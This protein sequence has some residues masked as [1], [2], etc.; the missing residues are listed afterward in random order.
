V[1]AFNRSHRFN[2]FN[3]IDLK[4]IQAEPYLDRLNCELREKL[5]AVCQGQEVNLYAAYRSNSEEWIVN[6]VG[7]GMDVALMPE[8]NLPLNA[9][10]VQ[11]RY[12]NNPEISRQIY[13]IFYP[14]SQKKL[15]IKALLTSLD[16][17]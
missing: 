6:L 16:H 9:G 3:K 15:E 1:V 2:R 5:K 12:L 4:E 11:C 17:A 14:H 10:D 8:Y 13:A 7:A